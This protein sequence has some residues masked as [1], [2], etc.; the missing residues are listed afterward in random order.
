MINALRAETRRLFSRRITVISLLGLLALIALFQLQVNSQ[1]A[2][3]SAAEV[4]QLQRE[5]DEYLKDWEANHE[6]WEADCVDSGGSVEECAQPRP[7]LS[8]WG[9]APVPFRDAVTP[10]ISFA[11]YLGGMVLFVAMAYFIGAEASTGSL[12]NWLTFIPNRRTVLASKLIVVS[13]FS[14]AVGAAVGLLTVASSAIL[15]TVH[16]QPLTGFDAVSA[17]AA[18]GVVVVA[19]FG[20]AGFAV[21]LL[22]GST[23]ASIGVLL[24]GIFVTYTLSVLAFVSPW[25]QYVAPFSP[26]VNLQAIL[27]GGTTYEVTTGPSAPTEDGGYAE[28]TLSLAQGLGYWAVLLGAL[29]ALSWVVFRRRDVT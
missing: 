2:P 6:E 1:V 22:T 25:A 15:T 19:I 7:E 21:G 9:L 18:R 10:A 4:A 11:V 13:V 20:I 24:G 17:M 8:E 26:G 12:A 3:P 23:G 14:G 27:D 16:G 28:R 5:F 29:V